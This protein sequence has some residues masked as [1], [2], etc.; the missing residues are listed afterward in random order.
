MIVSLLNRYLPSIWTRLLVSVLAIVTIVW[1]VLGVAIVFFSQVSRDYSDLAEEHIPRIA[2]ASELA[3]NS[4][5]LARITT[6]IVGQQEG[7][8]DEEM[9]RSLEEVIVA[10]SKQIRDADAGTAAQSSNQLSEGFTERLQNVLMALERRKSLTEQITEMMGAVRWLNIDIQDEVDPLLS[11]FAFNI[12]VATDS[13]VR[14]ADQFYRTVQGIRIAS[15]RAARDSIRQVGG[16]AANLVTLMLQSAVALD[17][18]QLVQFRSLSEDSLARLNIMTASLPTGTEFLTLSQSVDALLSMAQQQ[19]SVFNLRQEWIETQDVLL[20]LLNDVQRDLTDL[21]R[22]LATIGADQ[23]AAVLAVTEASARR[24]RLAVWW[25]IGLT[26]LAGVIGALALFGYIRRGIVLPLG[27]MSA[28]MLAISDGKPVGRL[29]DTGEDEIGKMAHAVGTFQRSVEARD[30]AFSQLSAEVSERRRA[31]EELKQTQVEL[32]QAGKLAALGQLSSGISHELNQPLA[33]MK[34]RIHLLKAGYNEGSEAKVQRQIERM[35]GLV[36]RMAAT[37]THLKRFARNSEYLSERL[38]LAAIISESELL[39]K[40][41]ISAP[42]ID[43]VVQPEL[44]SAVVQGDQI[45]IEQVVVNLLSN[46]L[47]AIAAKGTK[48]RIVLSG[49][50][51]GNSFTLKVADNGIGL[52]DLPPD[53]AFDPFVT[54]KDVGEGLGLGLSISY[55]IVK[56]MG[57]DLRLEHNHPAGT[58][59]LMTLPCGE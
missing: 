9:R 26:V 3:E 56:D 42:E 39:L 48:G 55:N 18:A 17:R 33:A 58:S 25:L 47:D 37:I 15:E 21:Q 12:A 31:V 7:R 44:Q 20:V 8:A 41:R 11:D 43:F 36:T 52:G 13:M 1:V 45:L 28:A 40:G 4:A 14:S 46:A 35:D 59:A 19:N 53:K 38:E 22:A 10:I 51:Q 30:A 27:E 2:L 23:R 34:H 24:S 29:P 54:T 32:V 6:A 16:E 50:R 5:K 57:G 49:A